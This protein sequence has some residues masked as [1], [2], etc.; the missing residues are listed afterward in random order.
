MDTIDKK[1]L[2][3]L[4]KN[5]PLDTRPF[6][7]IGENAGISEEEVLKRVTDLKSDGIIRQISPIFDSSR[8]GYHSSLC[9][10]KVQ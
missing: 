8:I 7:R 3:D 1:I 6:L 9:A 10:F 2:D 5:F 4:Q